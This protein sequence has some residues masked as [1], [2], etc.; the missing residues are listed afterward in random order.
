LSYKWIDPTTKA[1]VA[2]IEGKQTRLSSTLHPQQARDH[3]MKLQV[4]QWDG[5]L[6]LRITL[7]QE[8]VAWFDDV[9]PTNAWSQE[10]QVLRGDAIRT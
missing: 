10:V 9:H 1:P 4:P 6:I 3:L 2:G 8:M 7:V 5:T